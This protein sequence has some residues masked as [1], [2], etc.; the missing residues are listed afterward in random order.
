MKASPAN[1]RFLLLFLLFPLLARF[2]SAQASLSGQLKTWH[3]VTL[4][5]SGPSHSETDSLNPFT[6]YRLT[7]T[8]THSASNTSFSVPGHFAADGNAAESGASSG[9]HWRIHFAPP[10]SGDWDWEVDF[11][12]GPDIAVSTTGGTTTAFHGASGSFT[13]APSDK[14]A[15]DFRARGRLLYTGTHY[16]Q[17]E[18]DQKRFLKG[19]PAGPETFLAYIE[20]D[21]TF[22]QDASAANLKDWSDHQQDYQPGGDLWQSTKGQGIFGALDYLAGQ[23]ANVLGCVTMNAHGQGRNV[24]PWMHPDSLNRYDVSKLDQWERVFSHADSLGLAMHLVLQ[25]A[26]NQSLLDSGALG[27]DR[28]VYFREMVSRF[29]HHPGLIWDIAEQN[30]LSDVRQIEDVAHLA[31]IDPYGHP[32]FIHNPENNA[33]STFSDLLGAST[34]LTGP[35]MNI[36]AADVHAV[37]VQWRDASAALGK[38]WVVCNDEQNPNSIG[39]TPTAG[40]PGMV[41]P[42]NHD[43]IRKQVLYGNLMA[44]GAGVE[45][46]FGA[47][48][49][50]NDLECEDFRSRDSVWHWN[51]IA[52]DGFHAHLPFWEMDPRDDLLDGGNAWCLAWEEQVY[53]VYAPE[54]NIPLLDLGASMDSYDIYWF[55]PRRGDSLLTGSLATATGPGLQGLGIPPYETDQD[56]LAVVR[57]ANFV[58]APQPLPSDFSFSLFPNPASDQ[59]ELKWEC[60]PGEATVMI[61][62]NNWGNVMRQEKM[63]MGVDRAR[64]DC[65]EWPAGIYFVTLSTGGSIASRSLFLR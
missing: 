28:R 29:G 5:F 7:A 18:A 2:V 32:I 53:A 13:I 54:G 46:Y 62:R 23:G 15:P 60:P 36:P 20:F 1:F 64:I 47:N 40:Y 21:G 48:L 4:G 49:V 25:D 50:Q 61:L 39:V 44:G 42:D 6:D 57:N 14:A 59:V 31:E 12:S 52:L 26:A 3:P 55:D 45:Y 11:R 33:Q 17:F 37:S 19:G 10:L 63:P 58:A 65:S 34:E 30:S 35:S 43:D 24:W 51:K 38:P 41:G 22:A 27:R 16:L 9:D 8:F 56:W